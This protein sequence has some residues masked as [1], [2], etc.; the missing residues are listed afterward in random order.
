MSYSTATASAAANIALIKYWGKSDA[1]EN[2]PATASL[3]IGLENL[4]TETTVSLAETD[5]IEADFNDDAKARLMGFV[6]AFRVAHNLTA[7]L[8]LHTTNN[9]PTATGLASSASG[10]AAITLALNALFELGLSNAQLSRFARRGSGSA[11][12][13]I[14]GG[15]VEV[16]LEDDAYAAQIMPANDWPLDVLVAV[17]D[18]GPKALSSGDAMRL[19]AASSPFYPQWV[20]SHE[21]DMRVARQAVVSR[22]FQKL[23][24]ISEQNCLKMHA[25]MLTSQ[26]AIIFWQPATIA[27]MHLVRTLR[28]QGEPVFFTIDAGAQVKLICE[29]GHTARIHQSLTELP[30]VTEIIST[31]VNGTPRVTAT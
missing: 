4:R 16:V 14:Y 13:S 9:F 2:Q 1:G 15:Y 19:T 12:R 3:S 8:H 10:F 7:P 30:G 31:T 27:I 21:A 28:S 11:A 17:T 25:T 18:A 26:P 29:P 24:E 20:A 6:D 5:Q 23:A 22:D